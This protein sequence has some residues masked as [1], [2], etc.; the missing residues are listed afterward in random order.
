MK[1]NRLINKV[2]INN[3]NKRIESCLFIILFSIYFE[4]IL[5]GISE[6]TDKTIPDLDA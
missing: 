5:G 2:Q 6:I 1:E 3:K 4:Y